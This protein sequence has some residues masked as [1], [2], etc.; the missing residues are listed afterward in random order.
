[1]ISLSPELP[2]K[3]LVAAI[4]GPAVGCGIALGLALAVLDRHFPPTQSQL[5]SF[6][7]NLAVAG[8]AMYICVTSC[9]KVLKRLP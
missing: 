5:V 4:V 7:A 8:M 9:K 2:N 6:A 1:M 3:R